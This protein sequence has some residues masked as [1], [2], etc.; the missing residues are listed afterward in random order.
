MVRRLVWFSCGA[1]SA[2]AAKLT[3]QNYDNVHIAYCDTG[4]EHEDNKRFL[5][6]CEQWFKAKIHIYKSEQFNNIYE[7]F[8]KR[9]YIVGIAGA[10]CTT[11]LKK[12]VRQRIEN[13]ETDIQVFGY[14]ID[15]IKRVDKF[16][17]NNP[18]INIETPLIDRQLTKSDVL[19]LLL[20]ANID[21]PVMYKLGY[22]N[23]NCIGCVKGQAGYWNKIRRDFP[24]VFKKTAEYERKYNVAI[25]KRYEKGKRIRVFLDELDP[26]AGNYKSE[27]ISCSL[28]CADTEIDSAS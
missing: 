15:E 5:A 14:T 10:P 11:E 12:K 13:L 26:N 3:L 1:A 2:V 9:K 7:V 6:D 28:F 22:R 17:K 27:E 21:L 23:N 20:K 8:D 18:E 24:D 4:S 19:A 16:K 25:N